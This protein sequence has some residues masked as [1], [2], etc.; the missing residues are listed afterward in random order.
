[1]TYCILNKFDNKIHNIFMDIKKNFGARLKELRIKKG[2]TQLK[3]WCWNKEKI[4]A[5]LTVQGKIFPDGLTDSAQAWF[6]H[7]F[8]CRFFFCFCMWQNRTGA[9]V[10]KL[11]FW[12]SLLAVF[13]SALGKKDKWRLWIILFCL[14]IRCFRIL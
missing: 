7:V 2:L 12:K 8:L 14:D 6:C 11:I 13:R 10:C 9:E 1:M 5:L 3:N 4:R